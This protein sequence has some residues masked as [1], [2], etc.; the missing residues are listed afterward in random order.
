MYFKEQEIHE[1]GNQ[2]KSTVLKT[3]SHLWKP[4]VECGKPVENGGKRYGRKDQTSS[5]SG[6]DSWVIGRSVS[7][8]GSS[9][10]S[11]SSGSPDEGS[12]GTG[13][14]SGGAGKDGS[15]GTGSAGQTKR[16]GELWLSGTEASSVPLLI[17]VDLLVDDEWREG[18]FYWLNYEAR[19][20]CLFD[21][22]RTRLA[23]TREKDAAV[24]KN[25][26]EKPAVGVRFECEDVSDRFVCGDDFFWLEPGEMRLVSVNRQDYKGISAFNAPVSMG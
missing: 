15:A 18:T 16:L 1:G 8:K 4:A 23:L 13:T 22:P 25:V 11:A 6:S 5:P 24:I 12:G 3:H 26:G 9:P 19:Q 7:S 2:G 20:G 17:V 14:S 10:E 21:L